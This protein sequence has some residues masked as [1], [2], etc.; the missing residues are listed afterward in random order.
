MNEYYLFIII[1]NIA[2]LLIMMTMSLYNNILE[3]KQRIGFAIT[4]LVIGIVISAEAITVWVDGLDVKY[5]ML[6]ILANTIGFSLTP[7][8]P[9]LCG[10]SISQFKRKNPVLLLLLI[11]YW[12]ILILSPKLGTIFYV[13]AR[14]IYHRSDLYGIYIVMYLICIMYLFVE[15]CLLTIHYQNK[16]KIQ[17]YIIFTFLIIGTSIQVLSPSI[18]ITWL[19]VTFTAF[20]YYSYCNELLQQM[21]GLTMLLNHNSYLREIKTLRKDITLVLFDVDNFKDINDTWGHYHGDRCLEYIA[22]CIKKVY[23]QY[24]L[25]YRIGGD[26]FCVL[27]QKCVNNIE[28][29]NIEFYNMLSEQKSEKYK[30]PSVSIGHAKYSKNKD[31]NEVIDEADQLM[32]T[33]KFDRKQNES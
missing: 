27:L 7:M 5:R 23:G 17:L 33:L 12:I 20:F 3:Y 14:N 8:I 16:N 25:C 4:F 26:E 32:Y 6:H 15:T 29:F 11:G 13:D 24:G 30:V 18:R 31:I 28:T 21:D 9:V 2:V 22:K 10:G 1:V 19:C